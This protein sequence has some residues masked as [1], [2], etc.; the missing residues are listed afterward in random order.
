NFSNYRARFSM[1]NYESMESLFYSWNMGPVHFIA[2][3]TDAY[4]FLNFGTK[5]LHNL[6]EWL[7]NDLE[8]ATKPSMRAQ[9]PWII[10]Y[11]RMNLCTVQILLPMT[12]EAKRLFGHVLACQ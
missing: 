12:V 4:Y 5:P 9:R 3:H 6:Y 11:G 10:L 7:I 2:V 1:P 8:E